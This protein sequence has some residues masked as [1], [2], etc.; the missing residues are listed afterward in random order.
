MDLDWGQENVR[1]AHREAE[2]EEGGDDGA[3]KKRDF[4]RQK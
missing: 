2:E 3:G 4:Q 1:R